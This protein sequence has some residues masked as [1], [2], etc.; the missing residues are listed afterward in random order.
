MRDEDRA[1]DFWQ[2]KAAQYDRVATGVFGR[3][4]PRALELIAEGVAGADTVLEVA[5]G[6]GLMTRRSLPTFGRSSRQTT[7]TTC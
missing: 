6:T 2:R 3:P 4:L 5:A 7:L 1:R